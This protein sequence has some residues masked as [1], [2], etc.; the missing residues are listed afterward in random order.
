MSKLAF[1]KLSK[2][3]NNLFTLNSVAPCKRPPDTSILVQEVVRVPFA[4]YC[5][6]ADGE[7][8]AELCHWGRCCSL[9]GESNPM[10]AEWRSY[11]LSAIFYVLVVNWWYLWLGLLGSN[12]SFAVSSP[13]TL[14]GNWF[15]SIVWAELGA[16]LNGSFQCWSAHELVCCWWYTLCFVQF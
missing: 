10:K 1:P 15:R 12:F 6:L 5:S 16:A 9:L 11:V 14:R 4:V 3:S 2:K 13:S 8:S 7:G